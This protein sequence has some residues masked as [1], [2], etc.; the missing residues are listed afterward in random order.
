[1]C[2][3]R[4]RWEEG[5]GGAW[6]FAQVS[7]E[8]KY[9]L[10]LKPK[11]CPVPDCLPARW[12]LLK[13][14]HFHPGFKGCSQGVYRQVPLP[15]FFSDFTNLPADSHWCKLRVEHALSSRALASPFLLARSS[16][17]ID[18]RLPP[19][20]R[21]LCPFSSTTYVSSGLPVLSHQTS[22]RELKHCLISPL[23]LHCCCWK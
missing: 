17:S 3:A 22:I 5:E 23:V 13:L 21:N 20:C 2:H 19:I 1:M 9:R 14:F 15:S 8:F 4:C 7:S 12:Y 18:I 6:D 10:K 11:L 16:L